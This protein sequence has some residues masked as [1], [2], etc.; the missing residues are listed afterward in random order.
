VSTGQGYSNW[1]AGT[2]NVGPGDTFTASWLQTIPAL[3]TLVG[4]NRFTLEA[5]DVTTAPYNQPPYPP[6][7]DTARAGCTVTGVAP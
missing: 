6:S 4:N 2:T 1:R 7:G 5:E 3:G